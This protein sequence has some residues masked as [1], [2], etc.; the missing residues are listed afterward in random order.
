MGWAW[1]EAGNERGGLSHQ[2]ISDILDGLAGSLRPLEK[3][4]QLPPL[5]T[6]DFD[7]ELGVGRGEGLE[8]SERQRSGANLRHAQPRAVN[9]QKDFDFRG[10]TAV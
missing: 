4:D 6:V 5:L 7:D 9:I 1:E 2:I 3:M 10:I 8:I